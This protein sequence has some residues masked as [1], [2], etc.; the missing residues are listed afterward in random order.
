MTD[1]V[2]VLTTMPDDERAAALAR[3]LVDEQIA[4]CVSIAAPMTSTYRWRGTVE[5]ARERQLIIKTSAAR[6]AQLEA[7]LRALHPYEL[8]E[9]VVLR[10]EASDE[11]A[12]WIRAETV[13]R[14]D[15]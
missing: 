14:G 8:P 12:G 10:G 7:R 11:Y 15:G 3:A 6:L 5:Q 13:A 1:L 9:F 2:L 4:A